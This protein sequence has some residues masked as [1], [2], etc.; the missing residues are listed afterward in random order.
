MRGKESSLL[1]SEQIEGLL[2]FGKIRQ[3]YQ[4]RNSV[5]A[6]SLQTWDRRVRP[7]KKKK[8]KKKKTKKNKFSMGMD[9]LVVL[10]LSRQ[11]KVRI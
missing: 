1:Q 7:R 10:M 4:I 9:K 2:T 6:G 5:W 3:G 11:L 8:E